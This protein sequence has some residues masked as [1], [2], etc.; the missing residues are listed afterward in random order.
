MLIPLIAVALGA[1]I[2]HLASIITMTAA[3]YIIGGAVAVALV[4]RLF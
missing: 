2:L 3:L 4:S 1:L